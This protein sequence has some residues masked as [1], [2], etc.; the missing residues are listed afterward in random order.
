M[1]H[2]QD[3]RTRQYVHADEAS[4]VGDY[5]CPICKANVF[6]R[7]GSMRQHHF[8][9][10][11]CQ[12][13]RECEEFHPSNELLRA[14]GGAAAP[15]REIVVEPLRLSLSLEPDRHDRRGARQW[16]LYVILPKS[17]D[18]HGRIRF[19]FGRGDLRAISLSSVMLQGEAFQVDPAVEEFGAIWV[20]PDVGSAYRA[21]VQQRLPGPDRERIN[22]F[23]VHGSKY[24][25][26]ARSLHWGESYYVL[27]HQAGV[28]A[29]PPGVIDQVLAKER[30][31]SCARLTLPYAPDATVEAWLQKAWGGPIAR[32]RR[33][34]ALAYPAAYALD[35]D[36]NEIVPDLSEALLALKSVD[37]QTSEIICAVTDQSEKSGLTAAANQVIAIT[38]KGQSPRVLH[39]TWDGDAIVTLVARPPISPDLQ[40]TSAQ[41][42][43]VVDGATVSAALHG[44]R[45]GALLSEV[46]RG[47]VE[48]VGVRVPPALTGE[49]CTRKAGELDW[50]VTTLAPSLDT[51]F[52]GRAAL[53]AD[54][55]K[56]I[57]DALRDSERDLALTFGAFGEF[58]ASGVALRDRRG[59]VGS[60]PPPLRQ[61]IE[62]LCVLTR[63]YWT[64]R[65]VLRAIDDASLVKHFQKLRVPQR[66]AAH[67][68]AIDQD[69]TRASTFPGQPWQSH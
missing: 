7:A 32:S 17:P 4:V 60:L 33:E 43:F 34:W 49:L 20:S 61:R 48:L 21:T 23:E 50:T 41:C 11:P 16:R 2:A 14:S 52:H 46:R 29:F 65:G 6:L 66:L 5:V 67:K 51:T 54:I 40:E 9:H 38:A 58:H 1:Y 19:D 3:R 10:M 35:D 69:I 25:P 37:R 12:G 22:A 56:A 57:A 64:P 42:E 62:W 59:P 63:A 24:K 13:K 30:D 45:C 44:A 53:G 28:P 36:G 8:A 15:V 31:W 55:L 68:R 18:G 27:W 39:L 26:R 47:A